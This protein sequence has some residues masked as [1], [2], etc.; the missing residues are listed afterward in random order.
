VTTRK[1]QIS[2]LVFCC[3]LP[4]IFFFRGSHRLLAIR[5]LSIFP[6]PIVFTD[7]AYLAEYQFKLTFS[8]GNILNIGQA[9][10]IKQSY[11]LS[12][13]WLGVTVWHF[14]KHGSELPEAA[15]LR[16]LREIFCENGERIGLWRG[17]KL[18]RILYKGRWGQ[19]E[20]NI[21]Y[22]CNTP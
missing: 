16:G 14:L 7:Q 13:R 22:Q 21:T 9:E 11:E 20:R 5:G 12:H 3:L 6:A 2:A 17:R 4:T 15:F 10:L 1:V 8:D 19:T 18:Q